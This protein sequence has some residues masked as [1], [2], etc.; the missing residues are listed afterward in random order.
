MN[1]LKK[2][3]IVILPISL[4][5]RLAFGIPY[6][7]DPS[8]KL[9]QSYYLMSQNRFIPAERIIGEALETYKERN[10]EAGM[11][12]AYHTF[13]NLYKNGRLSTRNLLAFQNSGTYEKRFELSKDYF[14][15]SARLYKN[16]Q[17]FMGLTK[18]YFGMSNA[19]WGLK[20]KEKSC[21]YLDESLEAYNQGKAKDFN[22]H[23][24]ILTG[25]KDAREMI[26]AF[27][28]KSKCQD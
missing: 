5:G 8:K 16:Q 12:E 26:T 3:M 14:E 4:V 25:W 7:S 6:T 1:L 22:A 23:I 17:D 19:Y 9:S 2:I 27:K 11:A 13:G 21:E 20:N 18:S 15:K 10:D 28:K 24:P